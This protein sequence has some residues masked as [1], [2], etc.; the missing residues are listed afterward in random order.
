MHL[1]MKTYLCGQGLSLLHMYSMGTRT[2]FSVWSEKETERPT[3]ALSTLHMKAQLDSRF[4]LFT[5]G[6][7]P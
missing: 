5:T 4:I 2:C 7:G 1:Q 3:A 6:E